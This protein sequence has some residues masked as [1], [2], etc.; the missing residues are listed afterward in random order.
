MSYQVKEDDVSETSVQSFASRRNTV[1]RPKK[2]RSISDA[3]DALAKAACYLSEAIQNLYQNPYTTSVS[4]AISK[5]KGLIP[6][7]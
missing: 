2:K 5:I 1:T 4:K 6:R 7:S 3:I